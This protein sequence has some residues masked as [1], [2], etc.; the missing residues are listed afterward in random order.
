MLLC[1]STTKR[2]F[3]NK[4]KSKTECN[5]MCNNGAHKL[6]VA[7]V[8]CV[9]SEHYMYVRTA[10]SR[11]NT[12]HVLSLLKVKKQHPIE[13]REEWAAGE[14]ATEKHERTLTKHHQNALYCLDSFVVKRSVHLILCSRF[15]ART[16]RVRCTYLRGLNTGER[17]FGFRATLQN[18]LHLEKQLNTKWHVFV[19]SY[20][21]NNAEF[22]RTMGSQYGQ[23]LHVLYALPYYI[24]FFHN[25]NLS[26][27]NKVY[28]FSRINIFLHVII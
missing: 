26:I 10:Y 17:E 13:Q 3:K 20:D 23:A 11:T 1:S 2:R 8:H 25:L 5:F 22:L 12:Q 18:S 24:Y 7:T 14:G 28:C 4:N 9:V 16:I 6:I 27:K 21:A 15:R 19:W